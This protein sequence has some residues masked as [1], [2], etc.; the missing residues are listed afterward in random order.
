MWQEDN[1]EAFKKLEAR[2]KVW[3]WGTG[4]FNF[5]GLQEFHYF[6]FFFLSQVKKFPLSDSRY[7][8]WDGKLDV[9][10][11]TNHH[12]KCSTECR[13]VTME[14][15]IWCQTK[16]NPGVNLMLVLRFNLQAPSESR[17]LRKNS[18]WNIHW[19]LFL[20]FDKTIK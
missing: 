19:T 13:C 5:Q 4:G 14:S 11:F 8:C 20:K 2:W 7:N 12:C 10:R 1:F 3:R 6:L 17:N 9:N 15:H 18:F 16:S